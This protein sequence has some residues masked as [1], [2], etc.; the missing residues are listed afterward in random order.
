MR[1]STHLRQ[2]RCKPSLALKGI[3]ER[4]PPLPA[5]LVLPLALV[6]QGPFCHILLV[7]AHYFASARDDEHSITILYTRRYAQID[8]VLLFIEERHLVD[9]VA[10]QAP[11][12][13]FSTSCV[14]LTQDMISLDNAGTAWCAS[15]GSVVFTNS[16]RGETQR[17]WRKQHIN[18]RH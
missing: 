3:L 13:C 5:V 11:D 4:G 17:T 2:L 16:K 14:M 9:A 8:S 7:R 15:S 12:S 10:A 18:N 6:V 1:T